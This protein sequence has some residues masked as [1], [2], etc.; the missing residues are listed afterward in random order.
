M[1]EIAVYWIGIIG[2]PGKGPNWI[3][4]YNPHKTIGELI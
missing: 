3:E 2:I 1:P 4:P